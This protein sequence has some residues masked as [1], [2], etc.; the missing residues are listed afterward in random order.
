[1]STAGDEPSLE[2]MSATSIQVSAAQGAPANDSGTM[3]QSASAAEAAPTA[4][5]SSAGVLALADGSAI[6]VGLATGQP[7]T[8]SDLVIG[9]DSMT[10]YGEIAVSTLASVV[11]ASSPSQY[12]IADDA[13]A[14]DSD[15]WDTSEDLD[16]LLTDLSGDVISRRLAAAGC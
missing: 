14:S 5:P 7:A 9:D 11:P 3:V 13:I 12:E 2:P 6:V 8:S 1:V 15:E 4:S 10:G 16:S